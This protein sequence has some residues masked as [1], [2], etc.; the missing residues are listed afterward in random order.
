MKAL[1]KIAIL[2]LVCA[3]TVLPAGSGFTQVY[4]FE[5]MS[6]NIVALMTIAGFYI[7][8]NL[9]VINMHNAKIG[10]PLPKNEPYNHKGIDPVNFAR[11][12]T[13]DFTTRT[14]IKVNFV[15]DGKAERGPRNPAAQPDNWEKAQIKRFDEL[16][17]PPGVGFGE[18]LKVGE[19]PKRV[20][21]RYFY[22]LY[23]Q[24]RCLKCHRDPANSP[25]GDGKDVTNYY[26]ENYKIGELRGGI[27][28]TFPVS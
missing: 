6:K 7:A 2:T 8:D 3:I 26:M 1:Q 14:G 10:M 23:I 28:I 24:E 16:G 19:K 20:I 12:I 9:D 18:F 25:T 17:L 21:Y 11:A 13:R 15:S 4:D 22:P 5:K 27:S